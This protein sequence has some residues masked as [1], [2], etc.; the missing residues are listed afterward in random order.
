[1]GIDA[2]T[3]DELL[4]DYERIEQ[5]PESRYLL[6]SATTVIVD[7]AAMLATPR[8]AGLTAQADHR[9]P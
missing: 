8:F 3:L 4:V 7:E 1:M 9:S 6:S 5:V 2:D